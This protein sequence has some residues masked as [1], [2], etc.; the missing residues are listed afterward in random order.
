MNRSYSIIVTV[1]LAL[2]F[3]FPT[4]SPFSSNPTDIGSCVITQQSQTETSHILI[5]QNLT[6]TPYTT[7]PPH[8]NI[9]TTFCQDLIQ[10][11]KDFKPSD[12]ADKEEEAIKE[13]E[14]VLVKEYNNGTLDCIDLHGEM[15]KFIYKDGNAFGFIE[16]L[17]ANKEKYGHLNDIA[18]CA[19]S[20]KQMMEKLGH[21]DKRKDLRSKNVC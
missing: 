18:I 10:I 5:P 3:F 20:K 11:S 1:F 7:I 19:L 12:N 14:K 4:M 8:Q 2:F 21:E 9:S 13:L 15:K 6:T 16:I 17:Q